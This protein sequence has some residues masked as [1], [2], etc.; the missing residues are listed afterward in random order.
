MTRRAQAVDMDRVV[1]QHNK[2]GNRFGRLEDY[3]ELLAQ[4]HAGMCPP[5]DKSYITY[6]SELRTRYVYPIHVIVKRKDDDCIV[7]QSSISNPFD[8][9][10]YAYRNGKA[11]KYI[12]DK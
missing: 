9:W 1:D 2:I 10:T 3:R 4:I 11:Y 7:S 6:S 5:T 8:Y 12:P